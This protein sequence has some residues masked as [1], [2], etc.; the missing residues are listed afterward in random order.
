MIFC[1]TDSQNTGALI[2][3]TTRRPT[4][5]NSCVTVGLV[6]SGSLPRA[7]ISRNPNRYT[8]HSAAIRIRRNFIEIASKY[9]RF[10]VKCARRAPPSVLA[11]ANSKYE[12]VAG[13]QPTKRELCFYWPTG[14]AERLPMSASQPS[15]DVAALNAARLAGDISI[16]EYPGHLDA[17]L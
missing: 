11:K 1:D 15:D 3:P 17:G 12:K 2:P 5:V 4:G 6:H 7:N 14:L 9:F 10:W 8:L 16:T 13:S